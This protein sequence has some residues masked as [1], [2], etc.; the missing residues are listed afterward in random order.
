AEY[1][2]WFTK[3]GHVPP[4]VTT[5]PVASNGILGQP[6]TVILFGGPGTTLDNDVRQGGRFTLGYW[7]DPCR[8]CAIEGS[9]FFLEDETTHFRASSDAFPLLARPFFRINT[10]SEFSEISTRPDLTTGNIHIEAPTSLWGAE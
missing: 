9:Y 8:Q 10:G 5:G 4:L 6:G 7:L 3:G 2:L 1:L